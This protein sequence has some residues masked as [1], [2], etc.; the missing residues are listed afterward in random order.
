MTDALKRL[1]KYLSSNSKAASA[2][3]WAF[4]ILLCGGFLIFRIGEASSTSLATIELVVFG[5]FVALLL[6]P[7]FSNL[8]L[9]G[10]K[11]TRAVEQATKEVKKEV[12]GVRTQLLTAISSRATAV[13][14]VVI[15]ERDVPPKALAAASSGDATP[16]PGRTPLQYQILNT[17][18]TKQVN[19]HPTRDQLFGMRIDL[20]SEARNREYI[21]AS[22]ALIREG[23]VARMPDEHLVLTEAGFEYA[24]RN[25]REFPPEQWWRHEPLIESQLAIVLG[26]QR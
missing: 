22:D 3:Y 20:G 4:L 17:L 8:E 2:L 14:Y 7:L 5:V 25:Y 24:K 18:W 9:L 11:L 13:N 12:E 1:V 26:E 19:K 6:S 16:T 21:E 23:L 10:V 15:G